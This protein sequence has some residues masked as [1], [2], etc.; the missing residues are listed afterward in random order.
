M[1]N[2]DQMT[3]KERMTA[4][5]KGEEVD[6]LP[7]FTFLGDTGTSLF[8]ICPPEYYFSAEVMKDLEVKVYQT[9]KDDGI[10]ISTGL[11]GISE[12]LGG[13]VEYPQNGLAYLKKPAI[14]SYAEL[15][16]LPVTNPYKDGRLPI[17]LKAIDLVK[18][19]VGDEVNVSAGIAGP[20]SV[21]ASIRGADH[22]M[23]DMIKEPEKVH[24]LLE[25][26][27]ECN[28]KFVEAAYNESGVNIG[29][30]DP[31]ASCSLISKKTFREFAKPYL[32]KSADAIKKI[33]GLAPSLHICGKTKAIWPELLDLDIS[34]FSVDNVEDIRELKETI[35]HKFFLVGNVKPVETLKLGTAEDVMAEAKECIDK[36]IDSPKGFA[37]APGCQTPFNTP[38]ENIHALINAARLYGSKAKIIS[39]CD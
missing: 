16:N 23:R 9:F 8:G 24:E 20:L 25:F 30:A 3:A 14:E 27:T 34:S 11:R 22:L 32:S 33:T 38:I 7:C 37:L 31:V 17:L 12:A 39:G 18:K 21:A 6:R 29:M 35:G 26:S 2:L 36:A 5:S 13:E 28:L 10:S 4:Y 15:S 1:K 19:A